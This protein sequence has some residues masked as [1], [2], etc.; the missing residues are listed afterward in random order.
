M[1]N[2]LKIWIPLVVAVIGVA[3]GIY[4]ALL[5][6][7]HDREQQARPVLLGP[8]EEYAK[9]CL[10]ALAALR[11][12][13]PPHCPPR[14]G[15]VHRNAVLLLDA[16]QTEERLQACRDA[17]DRVRTARADVRLVFHPTSRSAEFSRRVLMHL[18]FCLEHA[19]A[20][21]VAYRESESTDPEMWC[22]DPQAQARRGAYKEERASAYRELDAFFENVSE[23]LIHPSWN[24]SKI[25]H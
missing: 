20:F 23:R 3:S 1:T 11:Y 18:R 16:A 13:T 7:R 21:Y 8:A 10:T 17:I 4:A 2:L 22:T 12:V 19:E 25:D 6:R 14:P 15:R 5:S 24:P 9:C